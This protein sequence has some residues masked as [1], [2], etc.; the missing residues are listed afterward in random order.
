M[1]K[2]ASV[3]PITTI[4]GLSFKDIPSNKVHIMTVT[5]TTMINDITYDSLL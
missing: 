2:G 3:M 4:N 1:I 5:N